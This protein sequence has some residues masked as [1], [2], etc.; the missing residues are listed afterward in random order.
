MATQ[1]RASLVKRWATDGTAFLIAGTVIHSFI[2]YVYQFIGARS[3]GAVD[4]APVASLLALSFLVFAIGLLPIEQLVIRAVTFRGGFHGD[5][6]P[7]IRRAVLAMALVAG[8]AAYLGKDRFFAGESAFVLLVVGSVATHS[9]YVVGRGQLAGAR[10]FAAYGAAT[11]GNAALRLVVAI[12]L[13]AIVPSA[14]G[15]GVA[16]VIGP[17]VIL[18]WLSAVRLPRASDVEND[19]NPGRFLTSFVMAAAASQVLLLAGPLVAAGM[20]AGPAEVSGIYV[21]FT[22][23]R[24]PL[25]LTSSLVARILPPFTNLANLGFDAELNK[26]VARFA[27]GGA[28]LAAPAGILAAKI[29]PDIVVLLFGEEFRPV[30]GFVGAAAAGII[31]AAAAMFVGQILVARGDTSR[32]AFGWVV[33]LTVAIAALFLFKGDLATRIGVA[34]LLGESAAL[35]AT[36]LLSYKFGA[37]PNNGAVKQANSG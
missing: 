9:L 32:L 4:F 3:L 13:L 24:A 19:Q 31:I 7:T 28:L 23:V 18:G 26:W 15:V 30:S 8:F 20:G 12:A 21:T 36:A 33:A 27:V 2:N 25:V 11:A 35:I 6:R 17:L 10:R 34:F 14:L 5:P 29:G 16:L 1:D 37:V 22:I